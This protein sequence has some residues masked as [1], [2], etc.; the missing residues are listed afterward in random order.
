MNVCVYSFLYHVFLYAARTLNNSCCL[1]SSPR[2]F[3]FSPYVMLIGFGKNVL[4]TFLFSCCI[5]YKRQKEELKTERKKRP[6]M[7]LLV[8]TVEMLERRFLF[9]SWG[10]Y[11]DKEP[12]FR[13]LPLE[14]VHVTKSSHARERGDR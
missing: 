13:T 14:E 5:H 6:G 7:V 9:G 12:E 11:V 8:G 1:F 10:M 3:C 2:A 4:P